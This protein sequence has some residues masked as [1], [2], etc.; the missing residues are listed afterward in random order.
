MSVMDE[1]PWQDIDLT[2]QGND[3]DEHTDLLL[4]SPDKAAQN[5]MLT[6]EAAHNIMLTTEASNKLDGARA[7]HINALLH[8]LDMDAV[9]S[10]YTEALL[11][12][13]EAVK[14]L[15]TS[16]SEYKQQADLNRKIV[17]DRIER[18]RSA[19]QEMDS[20]LAEAESLEG[21]I[22]EVNSI[23]KSSE[24]IISE[25]K[26]RVESQ[27][28]ATSR[29]SEEL[30]AAISRYQQSLAISFRQDADNDH[31]KVI[32]TGID[33]KAPEKEYSFKLKLTDQRKYEVSDCEP[34]VLVDT[35]VEKLVATNNLR[36]FIMEVRKLFVASTTA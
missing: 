2:Y 21:E 13:Q 14:H 33:N 6:T 7:S 22:T 5:I 18:L 35:L 31:V 34:P 16:L 25:Y 29:R 4:G 11:Q 15:A 9:H 36:K 23:I 3:L 26:Q 10:K 32:F 30:L 17:N 27:E 1:D 19:R 28:L 12:S 8:S 24:N 20:V